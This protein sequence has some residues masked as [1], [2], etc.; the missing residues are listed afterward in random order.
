MAINAENHQRKLKRQPN[1]VGLM[2][3]TKLEGKRQMKKGTRVQ[4]ADHKKLYK[5]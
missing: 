2:L 1:K 5:S 4:E 3:E